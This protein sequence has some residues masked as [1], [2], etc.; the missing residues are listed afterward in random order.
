MARRRTRQSVMFFIGISILLSRKLQALKRQREADWD[1]DM[2]FRLREGPGDEAFIDTAIE[3]GVPVG[4]S[5]RVG[6]RDAPAAGDYEVEH[7][8]ARGRG[9]A[10]LGR[11]VAVTDLGHVPA[12][13]RFDLLLGQPAID[14][15]L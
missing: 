2:A 11:V 10:D 4:R 13:D 15:R 6:V 9:R 1:L 5:A 12:D 8:L 14:I 3:L 7:E